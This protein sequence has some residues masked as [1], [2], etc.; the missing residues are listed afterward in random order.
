M[1]LHNIDSYKNDLINMQVWNVQNGHNL[2]K[3]EAVEDAEVTSVIP[4]PDRKILLAVGWSRKI[5]MYDDAHPDVSL[6][7]LK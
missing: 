5:M 6:G 4:L 2:H 7:K 1:N 3:L